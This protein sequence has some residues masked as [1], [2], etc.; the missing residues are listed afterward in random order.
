V[1][2]P[3]DAAARIGCV[4]CA[5]G[6]ARLD[7][8]GGVGFRVGTAG[9]GSVTSNFGLRSGSG[10][11]GGFVSIIV[12][13][14][15]GSVCGAGVGGGTTGVVVSIRGIASSGGDGGADGTVVASGVKVSIIGIASGETVG[16]GV[17]EVTTRTVRATDPDSG[18][19]CRM[20]KTKIAS[21]AAVISA[22]A[23]TLTRT[24]FSA[25]RRDGG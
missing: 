3:K 18:V 16:A 17:G 10:A 7:F 25:A 21:S 9:M 2:L 4:A 24:R 23:V 15:C 22:A 11:D 20:P 6:R 19:A 5:A 14:S 13:A 1:T 8:G 12:A